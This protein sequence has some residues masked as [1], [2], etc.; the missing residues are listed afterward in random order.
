MQYLLT[1]QVNRYRLLPSQITHDKI[2]IYFCF[3]TFRLMNGHNYVKRGETWAN[4]NGEII[5]TFSGET[6]RSST[7]SLE[8]RGDHQHILWRNGDVINTFSGET[9][10]SSTHSLEKRGR[11]QHILWRNGDVINTFSGETG[12]SS[13][14]SLEKRGYHQHILWRNGEI[15]NTFSGESGRSSTHSLD[16]W[17]PGPHQHILWRNGD[18]IKT[19]C[20]KTTSI[21]HTLNHHN[22]YLRSVVWRNICDESSPE[23]LEEWK[24]A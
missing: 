13:R 21:L 8:K 7:H 19:F 18:L 20:G 3:N 1:L 2:V 16:E 22:V 9:G 12:T 23:C 6:G 17:K 24:M 4:G 11:H 15:I 5:N 10:R 14:H